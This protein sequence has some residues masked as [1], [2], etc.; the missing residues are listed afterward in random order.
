MRITLQGT[1]SDSDLV[2]EG[3]T[4]A[5]TPK[6]VQRWENPEIG[7]VVDHQF[8]ARG[9]LTAGELLQITRLADKAVRMSPTLRHKPYRGSAN[10]PDALGRVHIEARSG[11]SDY[12]YAAGRGPNEVVSQLV[13]RLEAAGRR[14]LEGAPTVTLPVR[15]GLDRNPL[16]LSR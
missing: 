14:I 9:R 8:P 4:L 13:C 6:P 7:V 2:L 5:V 10:V 1:V 15:G 3:G 16:D 11:T 12:E